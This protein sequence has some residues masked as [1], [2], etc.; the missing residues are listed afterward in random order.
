KL[1]LDFLDDSNNAGRMIEGEARLMLGAAHQMAGN[2]DGAVKELEEAIK[3]FQ[4]ENEPLVILSAIVMIADTT[5]EG[6][7][8]EK[9]RFW[10]EKGIELARSLG[11]LEN[12][13]RLLLLAAT[14]A[15]LRGDQE[16]AQEFLAEV[17]RIEPAKDAEESIIAGGK[18]TVAV[19]APF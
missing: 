1:V 5:W 13:S 10:V 18:L 6:R 12:L 8:F 4:N 2:I 7:K 15:N 17:D 16:R 19:H 3:I 14:V 9:T 11:D